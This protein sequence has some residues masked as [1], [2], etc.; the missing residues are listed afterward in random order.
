MSRRTDMHGFTL[1]ELMITLA[2]LTIITTIAAPNFTTLIRNNQLQGKA[3]ELKNFLEYARSLAV[4]NRGTYTVQINT[5]TPWEIKTSSA[6]V[7]R[8]LELNPSQVKILNTT[9]TNNK[10]LYRANGTATAVKFTLCYNADPANGYLL[11][12]KPSG[13]IVLYARGKKDASGT[14]LGGC[15]P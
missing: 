15:T 12:V 5:D 9:L 4:T 2:L 8:K 14:N 7:K 6:A 13:S 3:E 10:L 1:V 11:E